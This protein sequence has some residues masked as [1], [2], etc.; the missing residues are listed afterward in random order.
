MEGKELWYKNNSLWVAALDGSSPA[1]NLTE[2]YD[3][4]VSPWTINDIG[5]PELMPP[6]WTKDGQRLSSL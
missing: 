4:H 3:L 5:Q 1:R 2:A 6:T